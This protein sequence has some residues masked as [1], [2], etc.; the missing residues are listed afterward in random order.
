MTNIN[1]KP[2]RKWPLSGSIIASS[3]PI[4]FKLW[5]ILYQS[6]E[7]GVHVKWLEIFLKCPITELVLVLYE[8]ESLLIY[9]FIY[10][11]IYECLP[12]I[13]SSALMNCY[14]WV[15]CLPC[16]TPTKESYGISND[17]QCFTTEGLTEGSYSG[18]LD[19]KLDT[20]TTRPRIHKNIFSV[21]L[22]FS[23][24]ALRGLWLLCI[25][26]SSWSFRRNPKIR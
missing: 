20:P 14:Q 8:K 12:R 25:T 1:F 6:A 11:F 10:L 16:E 18:L 26:G 5:Q 4:R 19:P 7:V 13:A 2:V 15:S 22:L 3:K 17:K 24:I 9:L 23:R 21:M